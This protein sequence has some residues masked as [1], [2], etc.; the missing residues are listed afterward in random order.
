MPAVRKK[1][2]QMRSQA[3]VETILEAA[4]KV[5]AKNGY[6]NTNTN[7]IAQEANVS[8]GSFYQYF[9][10]KNALIGALYLRHYED[11]LNIIETTV[12]HADYGSFREALSTLVGRML[13]AYMREPEL[14]RALE[15][16]FPIYKTEHEAHEIGIKI[17]EAT[18]LFI[19]K[20]RHELCDKPRRLLAY[21]ML[22]MLASLM[23]AFVLEPLEEI[24]TAEQIKAEMMDVLL[25][26][27][28]KR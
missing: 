23:H 12:I 11:M 21:S 25:G 2:Q 28:Q 24:N 19:E 27:M 7:L 17:F 1:P 18:E 10:N 3:M 8:I 5:L 22:Q 20:Y 26:Y 4:A 14:Q 13:A 6:A 15:I 9:P 16:E